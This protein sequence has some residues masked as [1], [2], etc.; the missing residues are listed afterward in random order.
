MKKKL[1]ISLFALLAFSFL[2][3]NLSAQTRRAVVAVDPTYINSV[4]NGSP[5]QHL[6]QIPFLPVGDFMAYSVVW[7]SNDWKEAEDRLNISFYATHSG[8]LLK[9]D[10][11]AERQGS[12]HISQLY[13]G[14]FSSLSEF[15][16]FTADKNNPKIDSLFIHFYDPGP[17]LKPELLIP[18]YQSPVTTDRS[19]CSCPQPAFE[20]RLDWCPDGSCPPDPTPQFV[21]NPTHVIIHHTAGT[22]ISSDWAAVVRSIW[23]FHVNVNGWD[24]VGYNWLIDPNGILYEG[25]GD[26]RLGAHFCAQNGN[27]TGICVMGDFTAITPQAAALNT[28]A[29]F[30][31]WET[32]DENIDPLGT[33]FHSGSGLTLKNISGHRDGCNTSCPGDM[34]YPLLPNVRLDTQEKIATGCDTEAPA[35]PTILAVTFVGQGL[36]GL[37]WQDNAVGETGFVLERSV[38]TDGNFQP[39]AQLPANST[40]HYDNTVQDGVTY[41]Y[42]VRAVIGSISSLYSNVAVVQTGI[43]GTES[44]L[45][46]GQTVRIS[47]NPTNGIV[48]LSIDNQWFGPTEI[49][50]FD[51]VGRLVV[52]PFSER[53]ASEKTT[54]QLDLSGLP[55]GVFWVRMVQRADVGW[56]KVLKN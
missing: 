29:N 22:N 21:P 30:L 37:S 17:T 3:K 48:A 38:N 44:K 55:S 12:R 26:G 1:T 11:H 27:T 9:E 6:L 35:A 32:C 46:S 36:V 43:T 54:I 25:R 24:D 42:R 41:F 45:L 16:L 56:F 23:D 39:L 50:V 10:G 28:L 2:A 15:S 47:P 33:S 8:H 53:K 18:N 14:K 13:F 20:G 34:F 52:A 5:S 19:A 31:A 51:V 7:Y 49:A 4:V 40:T